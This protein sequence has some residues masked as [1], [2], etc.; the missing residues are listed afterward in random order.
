ML[1]LEERGPFHRAVSF[2]VPVRVPLQRALILFTGEDWTGLE[3]IPNIELE[4]FLTSK[5]P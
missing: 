4:Y 1:N 2:R 5:Y 3:W